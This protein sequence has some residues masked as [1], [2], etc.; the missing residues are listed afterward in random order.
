MSYT[1]WYWEYNIVYLTIDGEKEKR[2]G[3]I[4]AEDL[5]S[6]VDVLRDFYGE[7]NIL[8]IKTLRALTDE[9][10]LEFDRPFDTEERV[11]DFK[12]IKSDDS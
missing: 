5:I 3:V 7:K 11:N 4:T 1:I 8:N 12:I 10:V 2:A 9:P 6:A